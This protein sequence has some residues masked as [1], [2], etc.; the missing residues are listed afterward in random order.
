VQTGRPE[1]LSGFDY[2]G[3][4][5]YFLT[6]CTF[7]RHRHFTIGE[8]VDMVRSQ[9]LRAA[10][11]ED[12]AVIADCYMPDHLHLL[13]DGQ[14]IASDGRRFIALA[15]QLSGYHFQKQVGERLWQRYGYERVLRDEEASLSVARYIFEN[16][17]R[18]GL[19][20]K[21]ADYRFSGSSVYTVEQI[22]E[23]A[24]VKCWSG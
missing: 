21:I 23:A 13:I 3:R 15:K 22:L 6:F 8:R 11:Q 20:E 18:A 24:C 16:P 12:M 10:A 5:R 17:V 4:H 1:R 2:I 14:A 9:I 19:V 7:A